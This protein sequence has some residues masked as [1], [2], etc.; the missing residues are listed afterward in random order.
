MTVIKSQRKVSFCCNSDWKKLENV[1]KETISLAWFPLGQCNGPL[2]IQNK[3]KGQHWGN[4]ISKLQQPSL[5]WMETDCKHLNFSQASG[6]SA[7]WGFFIFLTKISAIF[8]QQTIIFKWHDWKK[9]VA[10]VSKIWSVLFI[11]EVHFMGCF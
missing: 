6:Q 1:R 8:I 4:W 3:Q 5:L 7:G 11:A 9:C 10:S 2:V